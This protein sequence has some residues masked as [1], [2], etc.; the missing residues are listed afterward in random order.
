MQSQGLSL[1]QVIAVGCSRAGIVIE[2]LVDRT[3]Y[4]S[5]FQRCDFLPAATSALNSSDLFFGTVS[6]FQF[7]PA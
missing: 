1:N 3:L 7:G 4:D 6:D 5:V 2:S